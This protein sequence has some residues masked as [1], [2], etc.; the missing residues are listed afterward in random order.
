MR[1]GK[2]AKKIQRRVETKLM[3]K[4]KQ[5]REAL[6]NQPQT[7]IMTKKDNYKECLIKTF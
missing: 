5:R 2:V 6:K 3:Q 4:E 1:T 7:V